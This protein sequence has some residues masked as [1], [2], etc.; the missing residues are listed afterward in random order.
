M[1]LEGLTDINEDV[2]IRA[3]EL[4]ESIGPI[5]EI[6]EGLTASL[7]DPDSQVRA[8]AGEVLAKH[9]GERT[10]HILGLTAKGSNERARLEAVRALGLMGS[11]AYVAL[12]DSLTSNDPSVRIESALLL[13]EQGQKDGIELLIRNIKLAPER[14]KTRFITALGITREPRV[15]PTL[16]EFLPNAGHS[17]H[18]IEALGRIIESAGPISEVLETLAAFL[19]D[20]NP[21]IRIAAGNA[22]AKCSE[23]KTIT[24]LK[25]AVYARNRQARLQAVRTLGLMKASAYTVLSEALASNDLSVRVEAA[26]LLCEQGQNK[27]TEILAEALQSVPEQQEELIV[28]ILRVLGKTKDQSF[29][30]VIARFLKSRNFW[31]QNVAKESVKDLG[32]PTSTSPKERSRSHNPYLWNRKRLQW[33]EHLRKH[34]V[35]KRQ[36]PTLAH[37]MLSPSHALV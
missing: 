9:G 13:C 10:I 22:L 21:E 33:Q 23:E 37:S 8:R 29:Y 35:R 6:L 36:I 28:R 34:L 3:I 16:I 17:I 4:L 31:I 19:G 26:L 14:V 1:I 25:T 32:M 24:I 15:I 12:K 30:P 2:R 11:K 5:P 20:S 27:G 18:I 7:S